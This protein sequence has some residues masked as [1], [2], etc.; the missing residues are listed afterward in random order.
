MPDLSEGV[1]GLR[2]D[3]ALHQRRFS[4]E[5][6]D[7]AN[8]ALAAE[9]I[10]RLEREQADAKPVPIASAPEPMPATERREVNGRAYT[11]QREA[12]DTTKIRKAS[13]EEHRF[14]THALPRI[15][16]L[17]TKHDRGPMGQPSWHERTMAVLEIKSRVAGLRQIRRP[18]LAAEMDL[19]FMFE[20]LELLNDSNR[21]F[22]DWEADAPTRI[23]VAV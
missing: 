3:M 4:G 19:R 21:L 7:S 6:T 23:T 1:E 10:V 12:V 8:H 11:V 15:E 9:A 17:L 16:L 13:P 20:M 14:L 22:G 5:V 18:D 2:E